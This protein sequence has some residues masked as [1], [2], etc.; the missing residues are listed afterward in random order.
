VFNLK[1]ESYQSGAFDIGPEF[2]L[3]LAETYSD[4][5]LKNQLIGTVNGLQPGM[6]KFIN[7]SIALYTGKL[8]KKPNQSSA[9]AVL[10][11]GPAIV[12]LV[13]NRSGSTYAQ[14]AMTKWY[15]HGSITADAAPVPA[16]NKNTLTDTGE[17]TANEEVGN[18]VHI[19]DAVA[20][21]GVAP[22]GESRLIVKNTANILTVQPAFSA[23]VNINSTAT[24]FSASQTIL[25]ASGDDRT[26]TSGI[27]L[28]PDGIPD[29]Y[30]GWVCRRGRVGALVKATT[31]IVAG[32][33]LIADTGR[34][35]LSSTSVY[36][37]SMAQAITACSNDIVS[38]M[39][40]AYFDA[41]S[42]QSITT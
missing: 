18:F 13:C 23:V 26:A 2:P 21:G 1:G 5:D 40:V 38:D 12:S 42:P 10:L 33:S 19:L 8:A 36:G 24:I 35:T 4:S 9:S 32:K 15:T 7:A 30:W 14:G 22:E 17:F 20:G 16:T 29:N 11:Y 31:A 28:A 41:W 39:I 34:L 27:V 3:T 6:E 37:L 25:S